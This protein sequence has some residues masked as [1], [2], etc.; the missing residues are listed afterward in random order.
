MDYLDVDLG[1]W[2]AEGAARLDAQIL[3]TSLYERYYNGHA[4][5]RL[6]T[7]DQ[8]DIFKLLLPASRTNWSELVTNAVAER[9][10]VVGF[11]FGGTSDDRAWTIWQASSM[12]SLSEMVQ[13]DALVCG[14]TFVS[15]WPDEDNPTGVQIVPEH[16]S[17]T[18][19]IYRWKN[20]RRQPVAAYKR[21][22]EGTDLVEQLI[23]PNAIA[24][25]ER[26][27]A[28]VEQ[29]DTVT[30]VSDPADPEPD[31]I[32]D[33]PAGQV[34]VVRLA[35]APRTIGP[36]RSELHS[37]IP[38]QDRINLEIYNR[39]VASDFGAFRQITATG[40]KL[41]RDENGVYRQPFNVG[42]DRLLADSNPDARI[43]AI[44]ES[45]LRGY[46]DSVEADVQHLAAIT[47]TPPHYLLGA[48]VNISGEALKAAETGLVSKTARRASHLG[49]NWEDVVRIALGY[50]GDPGAV[51]VSAETIWKDFE[52]RSEG[53]TV[54]ALVK[55]ATLGVPRRIL[56]ERWGASP[57]EISRWEELAAAEAAT[58]AA[59]S[60]AALG[61]T[62]PYAALLAGG[63]TSP[64]STT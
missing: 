53:E 50:V 10:Q 30:Y 29:G 20:G 7:G 64:P 45:T 3:H 21:I 58:N 51:N 2:R 48:M 17:Q 35:G 15:V 42:A 12:D 47:Q 8:R 11:R 60:A 19:L 1:D 36:P 27:D 28:A 14:L 25:W 56:W 13:T 44:P 6:L 34:P 54:D 63:T 23:L 49:Q 61:A 52:T 26:D 32:E 62:D 46:L 16:P 4:V 55:M 40:V 18:T 22:V 38:I 59:T 33:N 57:Q 41:E 43:S 37:V 9:L 5:S 24:T 31:E 39:M